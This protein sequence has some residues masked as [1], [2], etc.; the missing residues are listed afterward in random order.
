MKLKAKAEKKKK[1]M[2]TNLR[3][4]S[5]QNQNQKQPQTLDIVQNE[6]QNETSDLDN[7]NSNL[8][9]NETADYTY[10]NFPNSREKTKIVLSSLPSFKLTETKQQNLNQN[11]IKKSTINSKNLHSNQSNLSLKHLSDNMNHLN[12]II[13][14]IE[15]ID[16]RRNGVGSKGGHIA[17]EVKAPGPLNG[18]NTISG[19][20]SPLN[21]NQKIVLPKIKP[22]LAPAKELALPEWNGRFVYERCLTPQVLHRTSEKVNKTNVLRDEI[23]RF[24]NVSTSRHLMSSTAPTT[25]IESSN[26]R[27]SPS[28]LVGSRTERFSN[29]PDTATA[30]VHSQSS[31]RN[32]KSVSNNKNNYSN[33][34][35]KWPSPFYSATAV[36]IRNKRGGN[37]SQSLPVLKKIEFEIEN[38]NNNNNNNSNTTHNINRE[39]QLILSPF[40]L[41]MASHVWDV[42]LLELRQSG[43]KIKYRDL[44]ELA[45]L[46][47]PAENVTLVVGYISVLLGLKPTWQAARA[48]LFKELSAMQTYLKEVFNS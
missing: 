45:A 3:N 38:I 27:F 40:L 18:H 35:S 46:R 37:V 30:S 15:S 17:R 28:P 23:L 34:Q 25:L 11:Q 2:E 8:N 5:F 16:S 22:T 7:V 26:N 21:N 13:Q 41:Q 10:E 31:S 20:G 24:R 43:V 36:A 39:Q 42:L 33:K 32:S 4:K 9:S 19:G 1:K 44:I 48:S 6:T 14:K 29:S 12:G 47:E